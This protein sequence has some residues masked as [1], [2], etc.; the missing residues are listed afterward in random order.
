MR[1]IYRDIVASPEFEAAS[2]QMAQAGFPAVAIIEAITDEQ[3]FREFSPEEVERA[4]D[5]IRTVVARQF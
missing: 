4:R 5:A 3:D 1:N 2:H